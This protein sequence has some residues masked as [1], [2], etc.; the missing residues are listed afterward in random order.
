MSGYDFDGFG[1]RGVRW[2]AAFA[3]LALTMLAGAAYAE[4]SEEGQFVLN[5]FSFLIWAPW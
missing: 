5:T 4:I 2:V 3:G 1:R